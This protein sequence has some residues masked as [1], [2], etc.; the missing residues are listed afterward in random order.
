[1]SAPIPVSEAFRLDAEL[2]RLAR[3]ASATRLAA[4][5]ALDTLTISGGHYDLGFSSLE[6]YAR[7]RCQRTGRWAADTRALARALESLPRTKA[8][9]ASGAIGWSTAELLARHVT[10]GSEAAW[11]EKARGVT[12]RAL[13]ALLAHEAAKLGADEDHVNEAA[14]TQD[15]RAGDN[16]R[17]TED[18]DSEPIHTLTVSTTREDAWAFECA[19]K[20]AAAVAGSSSSD[21]LLETLL[22]EGY[23]T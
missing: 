15:A 22:A 17:E 4:G 12:V 11:L 6:A 23:S 19:R 1:L 2:L 7:E 20:V 21:R 16:A 8:A 13:R 9:L 10:A 5:S 3:G 14:E 18:D